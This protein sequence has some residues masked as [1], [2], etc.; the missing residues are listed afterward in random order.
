MTNPKKLHLIDV[1]E[2]ERYHDGLARSVEKRFGDEI[3]SGQVEIN[4][5]YSTEILPGFA[6]DY[7]DWV[8]VDS[9]HTYDVTRDELA[10]LKSKVKDDGFI[11]GHDYVNSCW[12]NSVK[13]GVVE[14][15]HEF[16]VNERWE[17]VYLTNETHQHLSFCIRKLK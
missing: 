1:W 14:A 2:S 11:C 7:F 15:V 10:V 4:R 16:C 17:L 9:A 6:N 5:G 13:Y 8:Y 3:A 12:R